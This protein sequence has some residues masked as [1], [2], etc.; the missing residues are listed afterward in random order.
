MVKT[1]FNEVTGFSLYR[2]DDASLFLPTAIMEQLEEQAQAALIVRVEEEAKRNQAVADEKK[3]MQRASPVG[4]VAKFEP[5]ARDIEI[6]TPSAMS[7]LLDNVFRMD[8]VQRQTA[9]RVNDKFDSTGNRYRTIPAIKSADILALTAQFEN[10]A[11]P[12]KQLAGEVELMSRLPAREFQITPIL[13]L[14]GPGIGKTAFAMA[15]S[16]TLGVQFKKINGAEPSFAL[17]G[18]HPTWTKSAPGIVMEQ[19]ALHD[20]A[21]PLF[22]VDEVDKPS[23]DRYPLSSALLN[24][25]EPENATAFQDEFFQVNLNARHAI[26][27]LTANTTEGISAPLLSRMNVFNI[28]SPGIQQRSRIIEAELEKLRTRTGADV[29]AAEGEVRLLAGLSNLDLRQIT[30]IVRDGFIVALGQ[31]HRHLIF[32]VLGHIQWEASGAGDVTLH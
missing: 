27:I 1:N 23:G 16:K 28:P 21:A 5:G 20:C 7:E 29:K 15:L 8:S 30:R 25:L 9:K 31:E 26:W 11:E 13:L 3:Q 10:M 4:K 17:S 2:G 6:L 19:L 12:I 32:D 22:L 18:S 14:G 24:L